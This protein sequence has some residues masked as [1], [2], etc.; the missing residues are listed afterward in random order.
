MDSLRSDYKTCFSFHIDH[1]H[2]YFMSARTRDQ[3]L[4]LLEKFLKDSWFPY[5]YTP[6]YHEYWGSFVSSCEYVLSSFYSN[7]EYLLN[8]RK[9][10]IVFTN[11][12]YWLLNYFL[13]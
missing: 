3:K 2:S 10:F 5:S 6:R 13:L 8:V 1:L 4:L 9:T 12:G 11:I 7:A